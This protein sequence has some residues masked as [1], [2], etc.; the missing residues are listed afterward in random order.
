MSVDQTML[1]RCCRA[2]ITGK[3][4]ADLAKRSIGKLNH[5]RWITLAVRILFVYMGTASPSYKLRRCTWFVIN[6][7]CYLWFSAKQ[8]WKATEAAEIVF[9]GMKLIDALPIEEKE[10]I[11]PVFERGFGHWAHA[12]NLFLSCLGSSDAD[13]RSRAVA[14]IISL[15]LTEIGNNRRKRRREASSVRMFQLPELLYN[16][17]DFSSIIDWSVEQ[18]NEPPF[19]RNYSNDQLRQFESSPLVL[20]VPSNSQFVE[21]SIRLITEQGTRAASAVT[22]DGLCH[23]VLQRR[24]QRGKGETKSDFMKKVT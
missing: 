2:I 14:R 22:R 16:A 19:L 1:Y 17:S 23:A 15:R 21:R 8:K 12:E 4:P 9:D 13:I 11:K 6:I 20:E 10:V 24:Q 5:A 7:Y 3:C 18:V